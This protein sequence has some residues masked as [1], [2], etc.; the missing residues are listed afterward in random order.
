MDALTTKLYAPLLI[1]FVRPMEL[2]L[3]GL[4]LTKVVPSTVPS[5]LYFLKSKNLMQIDIISTTFFLCLRLLP[6]ILVFRPRRNAGTEIVWP[7]TA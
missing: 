7:R 1:P 5:C 3:G 6:F 2:L 4:E